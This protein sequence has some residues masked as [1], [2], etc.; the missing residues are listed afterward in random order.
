MKQAGVMLKLVSVSDFCVFLT[1]ANIESCQTNSPLSV[2][3]INLMHC[4]QV[5]TEIG[6]PLPH[7]D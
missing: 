2:G 1:P 3:R 5:T 6:C 4:V 7:I